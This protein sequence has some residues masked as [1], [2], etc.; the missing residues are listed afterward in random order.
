MGN[1]TYQAKAQLFDKGGKRLLETN[2][3]DCTLGDAASFAIDKLLAR[4]HPLATFA[5]IV[6]EVERQP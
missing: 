3:I 2:G 4:T 5:R 1:S 6:V